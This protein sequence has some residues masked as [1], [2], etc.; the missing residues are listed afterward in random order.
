MRQEFL[1]LRTS[2]DPGNYYRA[3]H[4]DVPAEVWN[5]LIE[6]YPESRFW[7]ANNKTVPLEILR[8]LASDQDAKVRTM[9][10]EIGCT[11]INE[12]A[13]WFSQQE[14]AASIRICSSAGTFTS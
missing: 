1:D 7:V 14:A 2:E 5:E 12:S 3:A 11:M 10:G 4:E 9:V 13:H 6:A 8:I